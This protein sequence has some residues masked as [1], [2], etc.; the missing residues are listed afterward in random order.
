MT[1][2]RAPIVV[3][4]FLLMALP[5]APASAQSRWRISASGI[6]GGSLP[7]AVNGLKISDSTVP[8]MLNI[9]GGR[10]QKAPVVGGRFGLFR[11]RERGVEWGGIFDVRTFRY[12]GLAGQST[13]VTGTVA[14]DHIDEIELSAGDHT[15]V[16]M[17]M[18][19]LVAR[20]PLGRTAKYPQGRWTPYV[21]AG[22]GDQYASIKTAPAFT[23]HAPTVQALAGLERPLTARVGVFGEYR[24]ER[25]WDE[26]VQDTTKVNVTLRTNHVAGGIVFRF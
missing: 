13:H 22:A 21:G 18:A 24:F 25:L 5:V 17:L 9:D 23:T 6:F 26:V 2:H 8:L 4:A 20:F 12:D 16:T 11:Q 7:L 10:N 19:A 15:R 1:R 3:L 14:G